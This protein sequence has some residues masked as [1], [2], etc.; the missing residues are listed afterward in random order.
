[1]I[2]KILVPLDGSDEAK[3]IMPYVTR[4]AL[5]L[6]VP[7]VLLSV[8]DQGSL[9]VDDPDFSSLYERAAAGARER[10]HDVA[11]GLAEEG[12]DATGVTV[13]GKSPKEIIE[14]ADRRECGLIAMS[15]HG[16]NVLARGILGSV[17][18]RVVHLSH[19]PVLA[20]TPERARTYRGSDATLTKI[21]APLDGS[22][23]AESAL[24]YVVELAHKLSLEVMLVRVIEPVHVF[25]MDHFPASLAEEQEAI[26]AEAKAYLSDM[27]A[28]LA[29]EGLS[30]NWQLLFGHTA[31][32]IVELAGETPHDIIVMASHGRSGFTRW[33]LG[34][35]SQALIR[36]TGDPVL[37]VPPDKS[38][39]GE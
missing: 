27:A 6:G 23:L 16:R 8:L 30:V 9:D 39:T 17:T 25:W 34:S 21:M 36:G 22:S 26:E 13:S 29:T 33:A 1:M 3:A 24:P 11:H 7:I 37:I 18:D 10:L 38:R 15:T 35:V 20:I 19:V 12:V 5:G 32:T 4:L 2:G 14:E 31:T 28:R